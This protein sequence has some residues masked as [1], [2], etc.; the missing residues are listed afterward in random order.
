MSS[1][2][3]RNK[4]FVPSTNLPMIQNN[5]YINNLDKTNR[6]E[7][8]RNWVQTNLKESS[9]LNSRDTGK[10]QINSGEILVKEIN[11]LQVS[12]KKLDMEILKEKEKVAVIVEMSVNKSKFTISNLF[13]Y[14][15]V[16]IVKIFSK[17]MSKYLVFI[18]VYW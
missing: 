3:R 5:R 16:K 13:L 14:A 17:K 1:I 9:F 4:R 2:D 8:G 18:I 6:N 10:M 11:D 7:W 15:L 12:N